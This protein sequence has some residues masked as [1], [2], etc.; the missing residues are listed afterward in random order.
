MTRLRD[1]TP[2]EKDVKHMALRLYARERDIPFSQASTEWLGGHVAVRKMNEVLSLAAVVLD[3][4]PY[5]PSAR[6]PGAV[7]KPVTPSDDDFE[8]VGRAAL[9]APDDSD[10]EGMYRNVGRAAWEALIAP[11]P[12]PIDRNWSA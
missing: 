10:L 6:N 9:H 8:R 4:V 2:T 11:V 12:P 1:Y 5:L 7:G 3:H